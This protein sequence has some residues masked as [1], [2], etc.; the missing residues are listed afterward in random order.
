MEEYQGGSD[1]K[2]FDY[3]SPT[4]G[5]GGGGA[6]TG[7]LGQPFADPNATSSAN[8]Q[9]LANFNQY[10]NYSISP[11]QSLHQPSPHAAGY[12][13]DPS[14]VYNTSPQMLYSPQTTISQPQMPWTGHTPI[15][16]PQ[17]LMNA[18]A[19]SST[20]SVPSLVHAGTSS[21][22]DSS[23]WTSAYNHPASAGLLPSPYGAVPPM[24]S[25]SW[26]T[27]ATSSLSS[28][29]RLKPFIEKLY[30][31]LAQPASFRDCLVWDEAGTAFIVSHANPRLL[32]QVLPDAFG[33]S[34]LHSFTRQLN[35]YGFTRCTSAELLSKLDVT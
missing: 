33:H 8:P 3:S 30:N 1:Q 29:A 9:Q 19:H 10:A 23:R 34:N 28:S 13:Y 21:A 35:I 27:D 6:G 20:P 32:Q 22:V 2:G 31:I 26:D 24:G 4:G 14:Q 5:V 15:Q 11:Q 7:G 18:H 25:Q 12:T 17:W 16:S